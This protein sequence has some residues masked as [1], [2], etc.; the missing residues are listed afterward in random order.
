LYRCGNSGGMSEERVHLLMGSEA[1]GE[2]IPGGYFD[3]VKHLY[4]DE[5]GTVVPSTTQVFSILAMEDFS[6]INPSVLEWKRIYGSALHLCLEY[7]SQGRLDWDTVDDQ[8]IAPLTGVEQFLKQIG[9]VSQ[10]SEERRVH[11]LSGMKYGMTLDG[12]GEMT[13]KG[14]RRNVVI[15]FKSASRLSPC[16]KWQLGAYGLAQEKSPMGW[17]GMDVQVDAEGEVKPHFVDLLPAGREFQILLSAAI[18]KLN[19]GLAK[20][21]S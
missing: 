6:Q 11:S 19:A 9:Y 14:Q 18:L 3:E 12:R 10:C 21:G 20:L 8:L 13:F 1:W 16:W 15:D 7:L 4:R 17:I 5:Q 2:K